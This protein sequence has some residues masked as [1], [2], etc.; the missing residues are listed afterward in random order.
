VPGLGQVARSDFAVGLLFASLMA[1]AASI[2]WAIH[3]T[4]AALVRT[5][6]LLEIAPQAAFWSV[7]ALFFACAALHAAAVYDAL[8]P[9]RGEAWT[10][11]PT[12]AAAAS[13]VLPGWGQVLRGR[14]LRAA[15]FVAGLWL[16]AG[17]WLVS[18]APAVAMLDALGLQLPFGLAFAVSPPGRWAAFAILWVL[19][20][21][22]AA[23]TTAGR[24][25][26]AGWS[27]E[28]RGL[29]RS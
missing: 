26:P 22:D 7:E 1:L 23:T 25:L 14:P 10:A 16:I 9:G 18:S 17:A 11:H 6:P 12:L 29:L 28:A 20:V 13:I 4:F 27:R 2:A 5:L 24:P 19:S 3:A 21:Y 15:A 8:R